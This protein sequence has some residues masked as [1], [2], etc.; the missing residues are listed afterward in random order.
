MACSGTRSLPA[1]GSRRLWVWP[2][3]PGVRHR[4][5]VRPFGAVPGVLLPGKRIIVAALGLW[6]CM[7]TIGSLTAHAM[8]KWQRRG[9]A[10]VEGNSGDAPY[11]R[12]VNAVKAHLSCCGW[13]ST[14]QDRTGAKWTNAVAHELEVVISGLTV[15]LRPKRAPADAHWARGAHPRARDGSERRPGRF[16]RLPWAP[17]I[18]AGSSVLP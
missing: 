1:S 14:T 15:P 8:R 6:L 2:A 16:G 3:F 11:A 18:D 7:V 10:E 5:V 17:V 9:V 4:H 12:V 13:S